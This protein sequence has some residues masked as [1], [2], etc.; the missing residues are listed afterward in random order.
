MTD[1]LHRITVFVSLLLLSITAGAQPESGRHPRLLV[2]ADEVARLRHACGI[3]GAEPAPAQAGRFGRHA[4]L[5]RGLRAHF[6]ERIEGQPLAG[7]LAAAALLQLVEPDTPTGRRAGEL[8]RAELSSP[9]WVTTD[10]LELVLALDWSW[11]VLPVELRRAF[12]ADALERVRPL[13]E[14]DSPLDPRRFR[15]KLFGLALAVV[16][17]ERDDPSAAWRQQRE[18][19]LDA[20][21]DYFALVLPVFVSGER[22]A[23]RAPPPGRARR[24]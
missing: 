11:N 5:Y 7:E 22:S 24:A 10:P 12:V 15:E 23:R 2:A 17:D 18:A 8:V 4:P 16:V 9:H 6:A 1:R 19:V 21:R 3:A 13:D 14:S 20:A